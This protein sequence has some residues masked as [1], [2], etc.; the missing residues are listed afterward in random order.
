MQMSM[1]QFRRWLLVASLLTA[2]GFAMFLAILAI[3]AS[4]S[5][6]PF[7]GTRN[8]AP[9]DIAVQQN[10]EPETFQF[11]DDVDAKQAAEINAAIPESTEPVVAA[12]PFS[13]LSQSLA[14]ASQLSAID[15]LTA[16]VYYE[17]ATETVDGQRAVAQVV[18]NRV[19]HP[20]YPNSV[21]GVVFQGSERATGCQ[22]TFTC[23]GSLRRAPSARGWLRARSIAAAALSG[24][25]DAN[26]GLA[27]H[28]HTL[29]VVPYWSGSLTK[30]RTV[31]SHIFYRWQGRS[32]TRGA[33]VSSYANAEAIPPSV[34][35]SL[36][37][38][39]LA[40]SSAGDILSTPLVDANEASAI[41]TPP[42]STGLIE[43]A[44]GRPL[45][46]SGKVKDK[47]SGDLALPGYRLKSD[48]APHRLL[49]ERPALLPGQ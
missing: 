44:Q 34:A 36:S 37:G 40:G 28:Y 3:H 17:S 27:T 24:Y 12:R 42:V 6:S 49:D 10:S 9:S 16:A 35:L 11:R 2:C 23:D 48:D 20:A 25:V 47:S 14:G 13:I 8:P 4:L 45:T 7:A 39:L 26:V 15:C 38:Y 30:L 29:F 5:S 43:P 1:G 31:G 41:S 19:R 32:G 22:F 33:F 46:L 18:L 21:C